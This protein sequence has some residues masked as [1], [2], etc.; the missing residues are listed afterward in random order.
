M[1]LIAR[2]FPRHK[3][4]PDQAGFIRRGLAFIV[5]GA[6]IGLLSVLVYL[7]YFEIKSSIS[8]EP[9]L[10]AQVSQAVKEGSGFSIRFEEDEADERIMRQY[11]LKVLRGKIP[12]EE[13]AGIKDMSAEEIYHAHEQ[14]LVSGGHGH[15][16]I[17]VGEMFNLIQEYIITL[18]YFV[19]FFHFGGRTPGKRIF[20]LKVVDLEGKP[21]LGWY[22][23]FE[24]AH[25]YVC[26]GLFASLGF[27]QVLWNKQGLSMHDKIADTTVIKLHK[28]K[29]PRKPAQDKKKK[30]KP[31]TGDNI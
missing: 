11:F 3:A 26:S 24:R 15:K 13:Y 12:D 9:G 31:D 20:R 1:S 28:E 8:H 4:C 21:R 5:D 19:F 25:G 14:E 6:I 27:W 16:F 29:K 18:L 17:Y 23:S 7:A 10:I 2:L 22:Q 30:K